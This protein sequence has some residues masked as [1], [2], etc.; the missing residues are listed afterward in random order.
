MAV[1]VDH[2]QG[3]RDHQGHIDRRDRVH[4]DRPER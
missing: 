4:A 2:L 1:R 3:V